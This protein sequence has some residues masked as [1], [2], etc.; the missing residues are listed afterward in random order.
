MQYDFDQVL[1]DYDGQPIVQERIKTKGIDGKPNE[2]E[3]IDVTLKMA[4]RTAL[5]A[6]PMDPKTNQPKHMLESEKDRRF[7]LAVK[8]TQG[9]GELDLEPGDVDFIR[10]CAVEVS[11]PL[12]LGRIKEILK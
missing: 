7:E 12:V 4:C 3:L 9:N 5:N 6:Y 8:L 2:I 10:K 1:T 11:I